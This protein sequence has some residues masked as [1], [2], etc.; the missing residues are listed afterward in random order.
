MNDEHQDVASGRTARHGSSTRSSALRDALP[1]VLPFA[2]FAL[3]TYASG[4]LGF[5]PA[6]A[7]AA[8]TVLVAAVL[9]RFWREF[10]EEIVV[11]FR[12]VD[13]LAGIVV[14]VLWV[15]LEGTYPLLGNPSGF[16]PYDAAS[17][18]AVY[19]A[20]AVRLA[21]AALV[22]PVME[23][24]F[25]RSFAMRFLIDSNFKALPLGRFSWFAFLIVSVAFG[26]EHHRWLP[27]IIAGLVYGAL[28]LRSRNLFSPILAHGVT[29]LLL[30]VYV[31]AT[32]S[33]ELW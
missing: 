7:Y 14:F 16:D 29:N 4:G 24:L 30:G 3:I 33:W 12:A 10:R 18:Q 31:L 25:W 17:G 22:V 28:L 11:S 13:I 5:P 21:G 1:Y 2:L 19:A 27:G 9:V 20:I 26:L 15:G 6:L 23:E 32:Q 8:K